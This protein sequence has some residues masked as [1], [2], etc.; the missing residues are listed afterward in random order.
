MN[1]TLHKI[2]IEVLVRVGLWLTILTLTIT[3]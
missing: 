2:A 1:L 3:G